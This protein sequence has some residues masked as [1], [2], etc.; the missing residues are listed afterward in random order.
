[1]SGPEGIV[2]TTIT[3]T[4]LHRAENPM[5]D[6]DIE[7]VLYEMREGDA[8]GCTTSR[9]TEPVN[10]E[11]VVDELCDLGNDGTFFDDDEDYL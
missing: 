10:P 6:Y 9:I 4:L 8:V 7:D 3:I 1:M 11:N 5:R 2:K